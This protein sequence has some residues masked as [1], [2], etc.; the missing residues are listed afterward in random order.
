[1]EESRKRPSRL[2]CTSLPKAGTHLVASIFKL[3]GYR[4]VAHPKASG[5]VLS[6]LEFGTD[7][8]VCVY[9]HWRCTPGTAERLADHGFRVLVVLRDP[10]D[11]CLSMADFIKSGKHRA[12]VAAEPGLMAMP[13]EDLRRSAILG[14][15]L[16]GFR[17]PPIASICR[18]WKEWQSHGAVVLKY[19][20]IGQ[21]VAS[22]LLMKELLAVGID[23]E[24]FLH[25]ARRRFRPTGP[26]TGANRWRHEFD[27]GLR[28][29]WQTHAAGVASSLGYEEL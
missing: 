2:M 1:M 19:E 16:P 14:L 29:L 6:N 22:G 23:P 13:L 21:S 15:E 20:A 5:G 25:A 7:E 18:G 27:A 3:M 17:S 8:E 4:T 24:A 28:Q 11:V 12:A 10:R 9:G 26:A